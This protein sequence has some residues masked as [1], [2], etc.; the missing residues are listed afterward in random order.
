MYYRDSYNSDMGKLKKKIK[1][2]KYRAQIANRTQIIHEFNDCMDDDHG[3]LP[4]WAHLLLVIIII[5]IPF[6]V[7]ACAK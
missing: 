5:C 7:Y 3:D 6:I 2:A 4:N 1:R